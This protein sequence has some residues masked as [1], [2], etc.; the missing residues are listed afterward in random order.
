MQAR[1]CASLG[2]PF[3]ER[4]CDLLA[5]RLTPGTPLTDRLFAWERDPTYRGDSV[6]LRLA[7][8]LHALRLTENATLAAVYPHE[9]PSDEALWQAVSESLERHA[10]EID[11]FIDSPPQ[12]NEVRRSAALLAAGHWL[13]ERHPLPFVLSELG[14]SGGLNLAWD[15]YAV[16]TPTGRLGAAD[17]ALELTPDWEGGVPSGP[18]PGRLSA[19]VW[20]STRCTIRC[21]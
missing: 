12:T 15:R 18:A 6:P 2:S 4:L 5:E 10:A 13:T 14:A 3:M 16:A 21:A 1:A 7:G 11:R 8:A 17:A 19:G 20:I 9:A